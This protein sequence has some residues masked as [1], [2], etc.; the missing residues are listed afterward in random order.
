V[1]VAAFAALVA[2]PG[3][4]VAALAGGSSE[5]CR[6]WMPGRAPSLPMLIPLVQA[7][8]RWSS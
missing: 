2:F 6:S 7:I 5:R 1:S 3:V 4:L 8:P